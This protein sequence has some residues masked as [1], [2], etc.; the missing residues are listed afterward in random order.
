M[1][2]RVK[3]LNGLR[4]TNISIWNKISFLKISIERERV[5]R[6][7]KFEIIYEVRKGLSSRGWGVREMFF[8]SRIRLADSRDKK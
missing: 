2:V 8:L 5:L 7:K 1:N 6:K 4:Y 3:L